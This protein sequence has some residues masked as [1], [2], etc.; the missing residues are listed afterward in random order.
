VSQS[1]SENAPIPVQGKMKH[2][3]WQKVLSKNVS[4]AGVVNYT[5]IKTSPKDLNTYLKQLAENRPSESD[6]SNAAMA[7]WMNAYNAFTVKLIVDN[8]PLKSIKDLD[9]GSPWDRKWVKLGGST[10]SLNNIEHD[11][12]RKNWKDGR[13][14]FAVNCAAISCPP[15][16]NIAFTASNHNAQLDKLTKKFIN[17]KKYNTVTASSLILS[18]IFDWYKEDFGTLID[19][20]NRYSNVKASS[21]ANV[22]YNEYMW[23]LNGK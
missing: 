5:G 6:K 9:N 12:L 1:K 22:S 7:Y 19:F 18:K 13:I 20:V 8:M 2:D 21:G 4:T 10:Y 14:H 11:I 16:S 23:G 17:S 15:L 3:L